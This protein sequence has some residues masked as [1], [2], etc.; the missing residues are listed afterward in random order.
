MKLGDYGGRFSLGW[1][2]DV[3]VAD[4]IVHVVFVIFCTLSSQTHTGAWGLCIW[5]ILVTSVLGYGHAR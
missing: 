1:C 3:I 4:S 2:R 5:G